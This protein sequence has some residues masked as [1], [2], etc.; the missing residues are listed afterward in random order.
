MKQPVN[1]TNR[2]NPI[3]KNILEDNIGQPI[4]AIKHRRT[5]KVR[6]GATFIIYYSDKPETRAVDRDVVTL[7]SLLLGLYSVLLCCLSGLN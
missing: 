2:D 1:F 5:H 6:Y 4:F 3:N 7:D